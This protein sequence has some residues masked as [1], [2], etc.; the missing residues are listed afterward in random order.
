VVIPAQFEDARDFS[1]QLAAVKSGAKWGF[2]DKAGKIVIPA[3]FETVGA[4]A[5]G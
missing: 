1:E 3:Q 5:K 4:F 2:I